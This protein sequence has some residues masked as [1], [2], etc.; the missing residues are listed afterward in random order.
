MP[1]QKNRLP[2]IIL[3]ITGTFTVIMGILIFL[4]PPA[5]FPD[6]GWGFQ[7]MRSMEMG[8]G[9]NL[10]I[11]PDQADISKNTTEFLTWWS[12]GQYLIPYLFKLLFGVNTGQAS[13][14]TI[15]LCQVLGLSGF[16]YFFKKIGFSPLIASVSIAFIACQQF[17]AANYI[18]Y[19]G[20]EVLLFAFSGWFLF[21]CT[22]LKKS[23][24]QLFL[25]VLFGGWIGF[26]CKSSVI[27]VYLAGLF[28]LWLRLS[29]PQKSVV[30]HIKNGI[31]IAIPA[32]LSLVTIYLFFLSKGENPA[33]GGGQLK[34]SWQAFSFPLASPLLSGFSVD[35]LAHG[36]LFHTG[37]P[38][39]SPSGAV[40]I[41]IEL[42]L[43]SLLLI[44]FIIR[45]VPNN[46]YKLLIL[47][48]YA[49]SV[50]FFSYAYLRQ[51]AISYE[52]RHF[53]VIGLIIIPGVIYLFSK[54]KSGYKVF[55]G[56][57]WIGTAFSSFNYLAKGYQF[58]RVKSAHGISGI[59]QQFI[60]QPS[61]NYIQS[62]DRHQHNAIF[63]FT[64]NDIGLEIKQNRIITL[65]QLTEYDHIAL[66]D[67]QYDGHA[68]PLFIVL[69][70]TS[71]GKKANAILKFFP[72]YKAF[73][74]TQLSDK[75]TL[76]S[77]K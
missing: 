31:W 36:L 40:I 11:K 26:L 70:A 8:G 77:A 76:Y 61:L 53:R 49:V 66:G 32:I 62:L 54:L 37:T 7:V 27:W 71:K 46:K 34:L 65:E 57:I 20:G 1:L 59:S 29:L 63:A 2:N 52:A 69:P 16:Y 25:F 74:A 22:A 15:T 60:D 10:L 41:L 68:G 75:Y 50:L 39:F 42:A 5:I 48:F 33:S 13:A 4:L 6:P 23:G 30:S 67:Y 9:F 72:E 47:V 17:Y 24:W 45:F 14:I 18:F 44:F 64:S 56:L 43:L 12:P 3:I 21:G 35:D 55:F 58:N 38:V 19:N 28:F 51:M 73:T